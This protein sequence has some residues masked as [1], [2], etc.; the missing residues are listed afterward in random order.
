MDPN[1]KQHIFSLL[2]LENYIHYLNFMSNL[3]IRIY[4]AGGRVKSMNV[5]SGEGAIKFTNL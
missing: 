1:Y 2:K 3:F 4:S 5:L